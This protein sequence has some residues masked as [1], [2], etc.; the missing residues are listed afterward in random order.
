VKASVHHLTPDERQAV[1]SILDRE[2]PTLRPLAEQMMGTQVLHQ[3][4]FRRH[5]VLRLQLISVMPPKVLHLCSPIG[6][7]GELMLLSVHIERIEAIINAEPPFRITD[8]ETA[9]RYAE[10]IDEWTRDS[11]YGE[12]V[13]SSFD[14]IPFYPEV[15]PVDDALIKTLQDTVS[16]KIVPLQTQQVQD[17]FVYQK[18]LVDNRRLSFRQ[19]HVRTN[20]L[21][22]RHEQVVH[23]EIPCPPGRA[24]GEVDGRLV[25]VG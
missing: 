18:W 24:W 16:D 12:L 17:G 5:R 14:D 22:S 3:S 25:P 23:D 13:L 4:Y 9:S 11:P 20:G 2:A 1:F 19:M 10:H 21:I 7:P 8:N 15:D 6:R